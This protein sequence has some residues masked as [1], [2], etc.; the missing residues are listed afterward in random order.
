MGRLDQCYDHIPA[1]REKIKQ[2]PSAYLQRIWYD[3]VVYEPRA[4]EMCIAVAG[5][6]ERVLYGSDY[7]HNIGDMPGCLKRV[8]GLAGDARDK[9]RG[10]NTRRVFNL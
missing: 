3:T 2:K 5:S 1:A 4:L 10:G 9:V 6:A 8:N 7:P